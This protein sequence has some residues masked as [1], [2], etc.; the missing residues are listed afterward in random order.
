MANRNKTTH[1]YELTI[2]DADLPAVLKRAQAVFTPDEFGALAIEIAL[3]VKEK[4][5]PK[6]G[7]QV[8]Y[9]ALGVTVRKRGGTDEKAGVGFQMGN[10]PARWAKKRAKRQA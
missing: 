3:A 2:A 8:I 1:T 5:K 4:R 7:T 6:C 10:K 9:A